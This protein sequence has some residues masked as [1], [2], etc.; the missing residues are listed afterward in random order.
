MD[1]EGKGNENKRQGKL[2]GRVHFVNGVDGPSTEHSRASRIERSNVG[3]TADGLTRGLTR[4]ETKLLRGAAH[5]KAERELTGEKA[6]GG[7]EGRDLGKQ[8]EDWGKV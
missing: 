2:S 3:K 6:K 4:R 5:H 8:P 7:V 1:Q